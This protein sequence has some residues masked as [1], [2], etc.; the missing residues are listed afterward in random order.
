[1][2]GAQAANQAAQ[3][4]AQAQN[5]AARFGAQAEN[6]F[7][8]SKFGAANQMAQ[9]NARNQNQ[10]AQ[11]QFGAENQFALANQQAQNQAARFGAGAANQ[12]AMANADYE[13]KSDVMSRQGDAAV[14]QFEFDKLQD[15]T[16]RAMARKNAAD[17]ARAQ[18]KADLIGGIAGIADAAVSAATGGIVG[19]KNLFTGK[20][21]GG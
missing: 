11:S 1:M 7:A 18:A 5:Q 2:F 21:I 17:E 14:Q 8:L 15:Q 20:S 4:G 12:A 6:Q 3:F 16:G 10:F 19:G 13:F 9:F